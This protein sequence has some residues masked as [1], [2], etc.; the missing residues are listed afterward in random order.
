MLDRT[1]ELCNRA[2]KIWPR[3]ARIGGGRFCSLSCSNKRKGKHYQSRTRIYTIWSNIKT[4]CF[5]SKSQYYKY[6]GGRGIRVCVEWSKSYIAFRDWALANGYACDLE[7]DRIDTNGNYTPENC[8]WATCYQQMRNTR[9]RKD[10]KTSKY[11]GVSWCANARK[12]RSQITLCG[13]KTH[14]GLFVNEMEAA[15]AYDLA[16]LKAFGEFASLNFARPGKEG[17]SS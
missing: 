1:C 5:N 15:K 9:K 10:G 16:A 7:L 3:T 11:K 8:R 6:Y 4:R 2:F 14:I 13:R 12:W 17:A